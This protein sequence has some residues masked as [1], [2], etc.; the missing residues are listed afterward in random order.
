MS[1]RQVTSGWRRARIGLL[2]M[3]AVGAAIASERLEPRVEAAEAPK[4]IGTVTVSEWQTDTSTSRPLTFTFIT[5]YTLAADAF[6]T[7]QTTFATQYYYDAKNV[8]E[9]I[10]LVSYR[11]STGSGTGT[12][13]ALRASYQSSSSR[14]GYAINVSAAASE[15]TTTTWHYLTGTSTFTQDATTNPG[16]A[17]VPSVADDKWVLQGA[18]P[19]NGGGGD[20][21]FGTLCKRTEVRYSLRRVDCAGAPDADFDGL[22]E[23]EEFDLGTKPNNP[24][25]DGDGIQDGAEVGIGTVPTK[26]DTDGDGLN[27]GAE[28]AIDTVPT[29]PDTDGDQISDGAEVAAGTDPKDPN[30]PSSNPPPPPPP[31]PGG[32]TAEALRNHQEFVYSA[33]ING[34]HLFD[35]SPNIWYC[36]N[37]VNA[38]ITQASTYGDVDSGVLLGIL[39]ALGFDAIYNGADEYVD[40]QGNRATFVGD[41]EIT[42]DLVSFFDKVGIKGKLEDYAQKKVAGK[43]GKII[44]KYGYTDAFEAELQKS[45]LST[46]DEAS[47]IIRGSLK[48]VVRGLPDWLASDIEA[49]VMKE[50]DAVFESWNTKVEAAVSSGEFV[51]WTAEQITAWFLGTLFEQLTELTTLHYSVWSPAITVTVGPDGQLSATTEGSWANPFLSI[52]RER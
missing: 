21:C 14:T 11:I 12:G 24:D 50:V 29:N 10:G 46:T 7:S 1:G 18:Q 39:D 32:C 37:G 8:S 27:D 51:G 40:F 35:F 13:G 52:K 3:A 22:D 20:V 36:W 42:Y 34:S 43:L 23:C 15:I 16:N 6:D 38:A 17:F 30:D 26:E 41:F 44:A 2:A 49:L 45:L 19:N 9:T 48:D 25:T 31:P 33:S 28:L 4:W 47:A 5:T